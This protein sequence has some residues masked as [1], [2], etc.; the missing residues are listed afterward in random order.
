VEAPL[1]RGV[2]ALWQVQGRGSRC[3]PGR[4]E[5]YHRDTIVTDVKKNKRPRH[6]PTHDSDGGKWFFY[7]IRGT[8][9]APG[10]L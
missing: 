10:K 6:N 4:G 7:Y 8:T 3:A 2:R 1:D 9:C 5:R